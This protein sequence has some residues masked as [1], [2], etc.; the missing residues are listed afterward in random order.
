MSDEFSGRGRKVDQKLKPYLVFNYLMKYSD[1]E[2][3]VSASELVAYL[4]EI[5]I[6]AERRSVYKDIAEI[7]KA[8]YIS[9]NEDCD[10]LEAEEAVEDD[11]EKAVVYDVHKKGFYVRQRHY[12]LDDIR[13]LAE[14]VYAAKFINQSQTTRLLDVVCNLISEWQAK[15][16]RHDVLLTDR[17]KTTSKEVYYSVGTIN[18][19]MSSSI[20]GVPHEPE[21][22]S[23][24]YLKYTI[25]DLK[26]QV[27]RHGGKKYVVSPFKLLM[28]DGNYY[29]LAY[30]DNADAIKTFRVDRMKKVALT[31]ED[32]CGEEAFAKIDLETYAQR[33]FS[34]FGGEEKRVT[35]R[36]ANKLLDT[37]IERFGTKNARYA[38]HDEDHFTVSVIV[39]VSEQFFGW[40]CGFGNKATILSPQSVQAEFLSFLNE[41]KSEY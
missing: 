26:Q 37:V 15:Q 31:G 22:I 12:E 2:H 8:I 1:A 23:F 9:E 35:I 33:V 18:E 25:Q 40:L 16:V 21:K 32:R 6:S 14:S 20:D 11:E 5:G 3:V 19:A 34:M 13:L 41:I 27:E 4:Q 10:I 38:T 24:Q 17:V 30:D 29:L 36:F 7:N 39:E 28:N